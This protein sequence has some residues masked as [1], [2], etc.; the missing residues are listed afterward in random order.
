MSKICRAADGVRIVEWAGGILV[1]DS[2]LAGRMFHARS[3]D[4]QRS[5]QLQVG[6]TAFTARPSARSARSSRSGDSVSPARWL[7]ITMTRL[8]DGMMYV[9]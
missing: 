9:R 6:S 8:R 4:G 2:I 3:K 1:G 5:F 7:I